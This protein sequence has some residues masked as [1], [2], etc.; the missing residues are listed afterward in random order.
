[1]NSLCVH[2]ELRPPCPG[3]S[4]AGLLDSPPIHVLVQ[5][6]RPGTVVIVVA[7]IQVDGSIELQEG[8]PLVKRDLGV[9]RPL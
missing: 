5:Q 8:V 6:Q 4:L 9:C 2:V 7:E 3:L 1:M